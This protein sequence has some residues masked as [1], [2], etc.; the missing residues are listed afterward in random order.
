MKNII[1]LLRN[2][3]YQIKYIIQWIPIL[4]QDNH[5]DWTHLLLILNFKLRLMRQKFEKVKNLVYLEK[6][7]QQIKYAEFLINRLCQ[8]DYCSKEFLELDRKWGEIDFFNT[9]HHQILAAQWELPF[10]NFV[11]NNVRTK[12]DYLL[13]RWERHF[14]YKKKDYLKYYDLE[15]LT[16]LINKKLFTWWY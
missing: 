16:K 7:I 4:W 6:E 9:K 5:F 8:D 10:I 1:Q 12:K 11:G 13:E 3:F 2:W 14:I 15:Q